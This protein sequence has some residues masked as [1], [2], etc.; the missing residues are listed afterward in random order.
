MHP[1]PNTSQHRLHPKRREEAGAV[2]R[3]LA[4]AR[5]TGT[6]INAVSMDAKLPMLPMLPTLI[7]STRRLVPA[8]VRPQATGTTPTQHAP[9]LAL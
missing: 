2:H 8:P 1:T 4:T 6:H 7:K 5:A 9:S 3:I